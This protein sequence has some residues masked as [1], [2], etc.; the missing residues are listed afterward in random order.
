MVKRQVQIAEE[1]KTVGLDYTYHI[2]DII[3]LE[4]YGEYIHD[5]GTIMKT[6]E[7]ILFTLE[8]VRDARYLKI[9]V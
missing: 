3:A 4:F 7:R 8:K 2:L 5:R 9:F 6:I 1:L